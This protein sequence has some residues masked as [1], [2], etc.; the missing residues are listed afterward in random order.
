MERAAHRT[1][2]T[3]SEMHGSASVF[4]H[5]GFYRVDAAYRRLLQNEKVVG[6]Q[7]FL[8]VV[9][10]FSDRIALATYSLVGLRGD[11][12]LL[13]WRAGSD[14]EALQEMA[15]RALAAGVGKY[16]VAS[17]S[18][19]GFA[20]SQEHAR[21]EDGPR[22]LFLQPMNR[23][24]PWRELPPADRK[25]LADEE[26]ALA[27]RFADVRVRLVPVFGLEDHDVLLSAETARPQAVL[28]FAQTLRSS[29]SSRYLS[30][31]GTGFACIRHELND[32][33]DQ[34]G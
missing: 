28:E 4:H 20:P 26:S 34:L 3:H 9:E 21:V 15:A 18:Y 23:T 31:N 1:H 24:A 5:F 17:Q 14:L 7:E 27:K 25:R 22:F 32:V 29:A 16:L 10:T 19:L 2:A 8:S 33:L 30:P 13:L 11:S 12:D 6:K